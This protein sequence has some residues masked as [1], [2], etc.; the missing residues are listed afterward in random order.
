MPP[1][2]ICNPGHASVTAVYH[3]SPPNHELYFVARGAGHHYFADTYEEHLANIRTARALHVV[4]DTVGA[5]PDS[6]VKAPLP[7]ARPAG[8]PTH[9]P[10]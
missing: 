9:K 4:P 7:R 2:P 3:P 5:A 1:G 6:V 10:R 8:D